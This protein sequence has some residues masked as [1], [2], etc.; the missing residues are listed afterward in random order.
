VPARADTKV[1]LTY[2]GLT[3]LAEIA[4]T[5]GAPDAAL[6]FACASVSIRLARRRGVRA[7]FARR[8][9]EDVAAEAAGKLG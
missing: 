5:G 4:L 6:I 1:A 3:G 9:I 7:V 8:L 2:Q